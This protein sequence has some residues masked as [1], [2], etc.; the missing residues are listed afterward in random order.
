MWSPT[1]RLS[2]G[3]VVLVVAGAATIDAAEIPAFGRRYRVSCSMCHSVIPRL[4][5]FGEVFAGNGFRMASAEPPRDTVGTGD[6]LLDLYRDLPLA[7]RLDAYATASL[8]GGTDTDFQTPYNI[9]FLSGGPIAKKLS[10]Y[11][12]FFLFERGEV[13]GIEDAYVYLDDIGGQPV[14]LA[15]GQFQVSDPMFKRELRLEYED[16]ALY[17]AR[18]GLQPADLTYDRGFMLLT[19]AAG[20]TFSA[21]VV[22]GNGKGEAE[23]DRELDN[24]PLKNFFAHVSRDVVPGLRL[25]AMGYYGRQEGT[26]NGGPLVKNSFWIIGAD[27]TITAGPAELNLQYI[28]RKDDNPTFTTGEPEAV[29]NGGLAELIFHPRGA[30][31]YGLALYNIVDMNLPLLNVRLGGPD[32]V[33]RYQTLT[34]GIGYVVRRNVRTFVETTW[35]L[36]QDETRWTLGF[37]TGF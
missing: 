15:V 4:S 37:T 8:N 16:Y 13:G 34:G 14:D 32:N 25:G 2:V 21:I 28:H 23:P 26:A 6:D 10:Y 35:D 36:E 3:L 22:N 19:D 30:R 33:E 31:W 7:V 17:R 1:S 27:A 5:A 29:L 24:D 12:Y 20:F 18:V 11:F 9:K